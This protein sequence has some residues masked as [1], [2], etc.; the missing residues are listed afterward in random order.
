M[1]LGQCLPC[2]TLD[3][4]RGMKGLLAGRNEKSIGNLLEILHEHK[5]DSPY[6]KFMPPLAGTPGEIAAL[7]A[8]LNSAV[9]GQSLRNK[10]NPNL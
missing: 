10:E 4:Y 8:Y 2:H 9:N 6:R 5:D 7:Q 3:G 1:F